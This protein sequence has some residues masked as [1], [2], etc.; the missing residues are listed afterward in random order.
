MQLTYYSKDLHQLNFIV[1]I[2]VVSSHSL[3]NVLAS[4]I[5][6]IGSA[7]TKFLEKKCEGFPLIF[8]RRGFKY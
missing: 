4:Q 7:H 3:L 5:A 1:V 6:R 2:K 8:A